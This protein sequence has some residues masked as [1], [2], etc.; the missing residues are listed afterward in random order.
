[1]HSVTVSGS[2]LAADEEARQRRNKEIVI[3]IRKLYP[4]KIQ[5]ARGLVVP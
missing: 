2:R 5:S 1:M 4:S 3:E